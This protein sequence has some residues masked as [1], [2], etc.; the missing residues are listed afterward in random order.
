MD[1]LRVI[2]WRKFFEVNKN[3]MITYEIIPRT[4]VVNGTNQK[5]WR[6][7]HKMYEVN[8]SVRS[9][10]TFDK[11]N[12]KVYFREK[13]L[14]WYDI[15]YR[16]NKVQFYLSTTSIWH[17]KLK[18]TFENK[19]KVKMKEVDRKEL[20]VPAES[21][22]YELRYRD[23]DIFSQNTDANDQSTPIATLLSVSE[24]MEKGDYARLSISSDVMEHDKWLKISSYAKE[25]LDK[26]KR[27]HRARLSPK[28]AGRAL[29]SGVIGFMNE[30]FSLI[31]DTITAFENTLFA[32][33]KKDNEKAKENKIIDRPLL[34]EQKVG[35]DPSTKKLYD[36]VFRSRVR[37]A[38]HSDNNLR[39]QLIGNALSNAYG[40][41]GHDNEL[42]PV[43]INLKGRKETV[44]RE[45]NDLKLSQRTLNDPDVNLVSVREIGKM[46][47]L[48]TRELQEKYKDVLNVN[49]NIETKVSSTL[50]KG[51]LELGT[52]ETKEGNEIVY[53]PTSNHDELCLPHV[54]IGSM[55]SGKT[56]GFGATHMVEMVNAGYG[57]LGIDPKDYQIRR[58]LEAGLP[59]DK[60]VKIDVGKTPISL[61][62]REVF[63]SDN[64]NNKLANAVLSFF[65]SVVD[66]GTGAQTARY[67]RA[68]VMGMKTGKL[69]EIIQILEDKEYT[70]EVAEG[71]NNP[72]HKNTLL[73][74]CNMSDGK[75]GQVLAPIYNRMDTILGD[76]Y[77]N[78][79]METDEG[80]DFVEL[81]SKPQAIIIDVPKSELDKTQIQLIVNLI[82]TK[83]DLAMSLREEKNR[84]PFS[85]VYDEPHQ[86]IKSA[87][88]WKNAVVESR[89]WRMKYVFMFH[90]WE[91]IPRDLAEIIKAAGANYTLYPSSK[92]TYQ[93]LKEEISPITVEEALSL[94]KYHAINVL[95][96]GGEAQT[97]FVIH[98]TPP[99][100]KK[101]PKKAAN[102]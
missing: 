12:K 69:S 39:K 22:I 49:K 87:K 53:F 34:F 10:L 18:D 70:K 9:R 33:Y 64:S 99:P 81:M 60:I 38:A 46:T 8:S 26:G 58:Q 48:P 52:L 62:W 73:D 32:G 102:C 65:E 19:L 57:A 84:F 96:V 36:R 51:G 1:N 82:T 14:I 68:A 75:R 29:S 2:P 74:L 25:K 28:V 42:E 88:T 47:Q 98:M 16:N 101:K 63:H 37:V 3:E 23:H 21:D 72:M 83:I 94:K 97:P 55:G 100:D 76:D 77:L 30:V 11:E 27:I 59:E 71:L 41:I 61:D 5:M 13:D 40:E 7:L 43:K 31:Q 15:V 85:I 89:Y 24:D 92:K 6:L 95:R 79:C 93:D 80:I 4:G 56:E 44:R 86:F 91:Q 35:K 17:K 20:E 66:D 50:K 78:Q 67:I 45:M 90:S 54:V